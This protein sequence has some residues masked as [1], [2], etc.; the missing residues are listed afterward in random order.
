V[1]PADYRAALVELGLTQ[2]AAGPILSVSSRTAQSYAANGP[3]GPAA[4][5][6]DVLRALP[7]DAREAWFT[8]WRQPGM[9]RAEGL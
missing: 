4:R 2:I 7:P 5:L 1:T 8:A 6:I 9:A 3:A